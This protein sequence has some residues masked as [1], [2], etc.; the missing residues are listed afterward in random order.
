MLRLV[1]GV[2]DFGINGIVKQYIPGIKEDKIIIKCGNPAGKIRKEYK[3]DLSKFGKEIN[4]KVVSNHT[5]FGTYDIVKCY[6]MLPID[7]FSVI[8]GGD[9]P[10]S[11][12][13]NLEGENPAAVVFYDQLEGNQAELTAVLNVLKQGI[14]L[15]TVLLVSGNDPA[16]RENLRKIYK[17]MDYFTQIS[18]AAIGRNL[19]D[20][21]AG[22]IQKV[23][24]F[25]SLLNS[26]W[27]SLRMLR[28]KDSYTALHSL[29]VALLSYVLGDAM[30]VSSL[31]KEILKFSGLSHD[32]GKDAIPNEIL[33]KK[34]KLTEEEFAEMKK[35]PLEGVGLVGSA[36]KSLGLVVTPEIL[37]MIKFHHRR[38]DGGGYPSLEEMFSSLSL[39]TY[40]VGLADSFDAM[41]TYRVY[42]GG[43]EKTLG[44]KQKDVKD[45]AGKQFH[46]QV[47][48]AL[49]GLI[50]EGFMIEASIDTPSTRI[51]DYC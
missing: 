7:G 15:N 51:M 24:G 30:K 5:S 10:A 45:N 32:L 47:A 9:F 44:E 3:L 26:N 20:L 35:H 42:D 34:G 14:H 38:Y 13:K 18:G 28:N 23:S 50:E 41:T 48:A 39:Y 11:L 43:V 49:L 21:E 1:N 17:E 2:H 46:P 36:L 22:W 25:N 33:N 16:G 19:Q 37:G 6:P 29:S 27:T 40:I 31:V 4:F 12:Q 8:N